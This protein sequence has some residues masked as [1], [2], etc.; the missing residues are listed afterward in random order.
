MITRTVTCEFLELEK[1]LLTKLGFHKHQRGG[2]RNGVW[3]LRVNLLGKTRMYSIRYNS[4][5]IWGPINKFSKT[6]EQWRYYV[7]DFDC[8]FG[9][10]KEKYARIL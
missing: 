10:K 2:W 8:D 1:E 7:D 5:R 3:E 4:K 9:F 6:I